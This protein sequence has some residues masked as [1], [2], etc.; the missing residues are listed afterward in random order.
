MNNFNEQ[1]GFRISKLREKRKLTREKLGELANISDRFIYDI[2][3]GQKGMS[4]ETLYKLS[5]ALNVTSDYL[6]FGIENSN[7]FN[8][9]IGILSK[10]DEHNKESIEKI[11]IEIYKMLSKSD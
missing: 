9:I 2:E 3:T 11:I 7:N 10:L 8:S 1:L 4:A 6:L 5:K